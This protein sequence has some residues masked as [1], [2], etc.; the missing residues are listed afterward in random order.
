[1]LN[2]RESRIV[3]I[4][5]DEIIIDYSDKDRD[6]IL[7]IKNEFEGDYIANIRGGKDLYDLNELK[8]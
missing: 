3:A 2:D 6:L 7:D 4:M 1:M 5:H 8:I